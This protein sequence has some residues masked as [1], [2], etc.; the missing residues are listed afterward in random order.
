MHKE[1]KYIITVEVH[2]RRIAG[3]P[4]NTS[5]DRLLHW[6]AGNLHP[7]GI[8]ALKARHV[9]YAVRRSL[10]E[11]SCGYESL[12]CESEVRGT[13]QLFNDAEKEGLSV[14]QEPAEK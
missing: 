9:L 10:A 7:D 12:L 8:S 11:I 5:L 4:L 14:K 1:P 13:E 2:S 6:H 3:D